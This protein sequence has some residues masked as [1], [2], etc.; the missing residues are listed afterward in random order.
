MRRVCLRRCCLVACAAA[1]SSG[2]GLFSSDQPDL[3]IEIQA[4]EDTLTRPT[5]YPGLAVTVEN[6]GDTRAVWGPG[7]SSCQLGAV[8]RIGRAELQAP[9]SR[10]C[11]D[12]LVE[13]GI[14]P[15]ET[16]TET[17]RWDGWIVDEDGVRTEL[18]PGRYQV[19]GA[20]GPWTGHA[21]VTI[22]ISQ[23]QQ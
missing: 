3:R 17:W 18:P 22:T 6:L 7:S 19:A 10:A 9:G 15:G 8:V 12:D 13:Q 20:A 11:T 1:L 21:T 5:E 4:S 14:D 16:R 2:C 23:L